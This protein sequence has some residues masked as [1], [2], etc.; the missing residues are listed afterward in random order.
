M[1]VSRKISS[2]SNSGA[3]IPLLDKTAPVQLTTRVAVAQA[4]GEF[5]NPETGGSLPLEAVA[6]RTV[7]REQTEK[8]Q[9]M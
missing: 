4:Q 6:R 3:S 5:E 7:M 9:R 8:T 1:A 2:N